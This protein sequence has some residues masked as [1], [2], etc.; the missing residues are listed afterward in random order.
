VLVLEPST[1]PSVVHYSASLPASTS[2]ED[3]TLGFIR[4]SGK[5]PAPSSIMHVPAAFSLTTSGPVSVNYGDSIPVHATPIPTD[6]IL[7]EATSDC[8]PAGDD[9]DSVDGILEFDTNGNAQIP[10]NFLYFA[11]TTSGTAC[12]VSFYVS[13]IIDGTLDPAFAGSAN[14]YGW[15]D[16][17]GSQKRGVVATVAE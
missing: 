11:E 3:V 7:L 5:T 15:H 9:G 4:Q 12:S 16:A 8:I 17:E 13:D 6:D 2:A 1:D 14:G 10:T